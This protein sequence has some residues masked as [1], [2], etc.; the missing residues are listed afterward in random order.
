MVH[1][2]FPGSAL[3]VGHAAERSS[4]IVLRRHFRVPLPCPAIVL[5]AII[6]A[7]QATLN[8]RERT[9]GDVYRRHPK[10]TVTTEIADGESVR[11]GGRDA[12]ATICPIAIA[13]EPHRAIGLLV[14]G[15]IGH[16]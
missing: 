12:P 6:A 5:H 1:D 13:I 16:R 2:A 14:S 4:H 8:A 11:P 3:V 9:K 7:A 15:E 10:G